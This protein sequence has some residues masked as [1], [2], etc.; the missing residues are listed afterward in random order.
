MQWAEEAS[1]LNQPIWLTPLRSGLPPT[2][3]ITVNEHLGHRPD[4]WGAIRAREKE[5]YGYNY[6]PAAATSTPLTASIVPP[7]FAY[8]VI[9]HPFPKPFIVHDMDK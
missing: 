6:E 8:E 5:R 3:P 1:A 4:L 2:S 9:T 7:Y